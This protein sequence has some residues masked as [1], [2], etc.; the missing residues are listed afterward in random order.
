MEESPRRVKRIAEFVDKEDGSVEV[1]V[2]A[3]C[4]YYGNKVTVPV[5]ETAVF[6]PDDGEDM[7]R[8]LTETLAVPVEETLRLVQDAYSDSLCERTPAAPTQLV[9]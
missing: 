9:A 3:E 5:G 2:K 6:R 1:T 7:E 4:L 8:W